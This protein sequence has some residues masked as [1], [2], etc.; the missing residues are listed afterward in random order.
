[1][2]DILK[3]LIGVIA[4]FTLSLVFA[5]VVNQTKVGSGQ[6]NQFSTGT[7]TSASV[8]TS[9]TSIVAGNSGRQYLVLVNDGAN[10]VYL[11]FGATAVANKG[12]RLNASGGTLEINQD[13]LFTGAIN[14]IATGGTSVVTVFEK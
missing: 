7:N 11:G 14:G 2:K 8:T 1:M 6:I 12:I 5:P 9:N 13:N 4:G 10:P 3:V